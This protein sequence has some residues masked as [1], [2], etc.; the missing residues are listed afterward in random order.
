MP[1]QVLRISEVVIRQQTPRSPLGSPKRPLE[2]PGGHR[3]ADP[4]CSW[5]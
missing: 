1:A 2:A 3:V 5:N 4:R